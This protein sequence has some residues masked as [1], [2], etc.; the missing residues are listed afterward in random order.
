MAMYGY[1]GLCM[2]TYGYVEQCRAM[3]YSATNRY[4]IYE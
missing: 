3:Q 4:A 1:V 2:A